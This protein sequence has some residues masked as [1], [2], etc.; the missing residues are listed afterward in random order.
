[1]KAKT[2]L[3][4][5]LKTK[6]KKTM[7]K[8]TTKKRILPVAKRG[9]ILPIL[10]M[11][12]ALGSL[13]AGAA[14]V[15]KA[16][17]DS[18]A[19]QRQLQEMQRHHRAMEGR[20]LYFAPYKNGQ[21]LYLAPYKQGQGAVTKKGAAGVAKAV[22]DSKAVQRQLQEMQRHHRAMEGRGLYFAPYK[23]G[24]GLYLAPY[25]R[26]QGAVTKKKNVKRR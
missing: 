26:E 20:G 14:G 17:N 23:N 7:K 18:K 4:M 8:R 16:V 13:A 21:G 9:G 2:K 3:G 11:L 15:A 24:Q 25:K 10:P 5:G 12:G 1:M 22:N 19:V 6:K